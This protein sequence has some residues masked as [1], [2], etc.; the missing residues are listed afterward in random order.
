MPEKQSN[1]LLNWMKW[2]SNS[3]ILLEQGNEYA[4]EYSRWF[5]NCQAAGPD[6]L[7]TGNLRQML[8]IEG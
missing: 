6:A 1:P 3:G 5:R 2:E 7:E 8:S 4:L